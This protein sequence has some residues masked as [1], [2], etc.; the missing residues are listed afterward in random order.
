MIS[1]EYGFMSITFTSFRNPAWED[2]IDLELNTQLESKTGLHKA[3]SQGIYSFYETQHIGGA[4]FQK[5]GN[6]IWLE[7][8]Y[9]DTAF[10]RKGI[11]RK[12]IQEVIEYGQQHQVQTLQLN[13]YFEEARDFFKS[14]NFEEITS[15]PNWKYGLTCYFMKKKL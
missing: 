1:T 13:T 12:L 2:K 9:I 4:I 7:G 14:C 8:F 6:I 11:G 10:R 15:I 5:Q 3:Q